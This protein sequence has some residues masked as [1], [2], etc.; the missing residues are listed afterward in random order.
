MEVIYVEFFDSKS[1]AMKEKTP[2]NWS[3]TRI[4]SKLI[5]YNRRVLIR[6]RKLKKKRI[7]DDK[8]FQLSFSCYQAY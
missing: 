5:A 3:G 2:Q 1:E 4:Y 7:R 8:L 6:R